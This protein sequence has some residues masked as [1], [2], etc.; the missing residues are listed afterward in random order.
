MEIRVKMSKYNVK[1][2]GAVCECSKM[3]ALR[4]F[5]TSECSNIYFFCFFSL[6][7]ALFVCYV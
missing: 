1:M 6:F 2:C 4:A 3:T 5:R 7:L